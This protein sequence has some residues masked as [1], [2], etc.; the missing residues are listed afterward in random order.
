MEKNIS[1]RSFLKVL[2]GSAVASAPLLAGCKGAGKDESASQQEP[3]KGK[4][5]YRTNHNNGDKVSILGYGMMRLPVV[6]KGSAREQADEAI[7]QE[8][9][10]REVDYA[11]EHGVNYFDT[12]PAYC[13][14]LSERATGIALKRHDRSKYFVAKRQSAPTPPPST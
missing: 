5:T 11:I 12:S 13:Q 14:G 7:D 3:P 9:V 1:R 4:M 8:M 10:N 6:G 2:G